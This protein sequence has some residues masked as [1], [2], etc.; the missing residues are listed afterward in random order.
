MAW[1]DW[2]D[3]ALGRITFGEYAGMARVP[4]GPQAEG[5]ASGLR[6]GEATAPR[7]RLAPP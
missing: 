4:C 2:T 5:P 1:G 3:P 6:W 7:V